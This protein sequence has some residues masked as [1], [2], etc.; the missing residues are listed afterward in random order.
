MFDRLTERFQ[1]VFRDLRG[2][3]RLSE[4]NIQDALREVR[5]ALLEADVHYPTVKSFV[6]RVKTKCIGQEVLQSVSPGQQFVKAVHDELVALLGSTTADFA[7]LP[8]PASI[9]MIGLHGSGK[10]TTTGKLAR[11]W[12]KDGKKVVVAACDIR[13]PAAV[14]QLAALAAACGAACVRPEPGDS[15]PDV[16]RRAARAA[17]DSLADVVLYDTG[18]RF[19]M[20][21][22]LL[23]ELAALRDAVHPRDTVLVLDAAIGQESVAVAKAFHDRLGLTGLILT[24]LDGDARG[25]A[26]LSVVSVVGC[27]ILRV[28]VGEQPDDLEPFHPD[29]MA[30]RILGMGDVVSL[31]EK[32]QATVDADEAA[33]LQNQVIGRGRLTLDDLLAQMRQLKRFGSLSK[34]MDL[35]PGASSIPRDLR[36]RAQTEGMA[37]MKVSEAVILSMTP[38]ERRHPEILDARRRRRIAAGSGTTVADVNDLIRQ[39]NQMRKMAKK[40]KGMS[41]FF[42]RPH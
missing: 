5:M 29:R 25:G 19:Q 15:V 24:K 8:P 16:A 27:P 4:K 3:S 14:D 1:K 41:R 26:A 33:R 38:R 22:D 7:L 35:I 13:R 34:V 28:G 37:R 39:F 30:S 10:T 31:V 23:A 21:D 32:V 42:P 40:M 20:D 9:M 6:D 2:T 17:R 11:Q 36:D 12:I 18:G